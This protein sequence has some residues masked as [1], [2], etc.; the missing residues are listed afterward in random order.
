M[1]SNFSS[2]QK[3]NDPHFWGELQSELDLLITRGQHIEAKQIFE[4]INPKHIPRSYGVVF[5]ELAWRTGS[6]L[7]CL[8]ILHPV[9]FPENNFNPLATAAE[10]MNYA[11]ALVNLGA[12][13]EAIEIFNNVDALVHP[14][15][16]LR[17]SFAYFKKWDYE[18][19]IHWLQQYTQHP[20]VPPYKKLVGQVNLAAAYVD[21][22]LWSEAT[23]LLSQI[24]SECRKNSYLL[25]LANCL[26]LQA[27]YEI[28]N[29]QFAAA[30]KKLD[31]AM[32]YLKNQQG[33]FLLFAEKWI[34]VCDAFQNRDEKS[35]AALKEIRKAAVSLANWET[36]RDVDL[37][38]A[39]IAQD[40]D[41]AKKILIGT[42]SEK[43]RNRVRRLFGKHLISRGNYY[44]TLQGLDLTTTTTLQFNP[45]DLQKNGQA[46]SSAPQLLKLFEALTFDFYKPSHIGLLFL[47]IYKDEK[48]N[49]FT[50]P[51][52]VLKLIKRLNRWFI[53]NEISLAVNMKKSE[54]RLIAK[55]NTVRIMIQRA[56]PLSKKQGIF[57]QL[58]LIFKDRSFSTA[59]V[60]QQMNI[61]KSSAAALVRQAQQD[62]D[63]VLRGQG[64]PALYQIASRQNKKVA[65]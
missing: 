20:S 6:P 24:E 17:K 60:A 22:L 46:L 13:S 21:T 56:Q 44:L 8:Q 31:E 54:F 65:A 36:V 64:R 26:E 18:T 47:S 38:E 5:S 35:L 59:Q 34:A 15:V 10:K 43:Y 25:L 45:Y 48:F 14:E 3:Q 33:S 40:D 63:L 29:Q 12:L 1:P 61:S 27:Q 50:S 42:P 7:Y 55:N 58:K 4:Q 2:L 11:S 53:Q 51:D 30:R 39:V 19:P 23:V 62:G 57:K 52:R 9:V 49:P 37:F 41:L 16:L 28:F 32:G